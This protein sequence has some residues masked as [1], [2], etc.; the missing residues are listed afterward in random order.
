MELVRDDT[1][2]DVRRY[3]ELLAEVCNSITEPFG[4]TVETGINFP[5][6]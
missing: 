2:Y 6:A 3:V 1:Q 5:I 4:F